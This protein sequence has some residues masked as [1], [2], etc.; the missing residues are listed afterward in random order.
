MG[1]GLRAKYLLP[2]CC[3]FKKNPI[4]FYLTCNMTMLWKS[5]IMTY[6]PHRQGPGLGLCAQNVGYHVAAFVILLNLICNMTMFWKLN[7]D[8]LT[9]DLVTFPLV[10]WV[11][12][13]IWLYRFLIFASLLTIDPIPRVARG[14]G[15]RLW[16]KYL[17][18]FR[19]IR[20]SL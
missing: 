20:G 19:C 16:A 14:G 13:G 9:Y 6:L 10:S 18:P 5:W 2:C 4:T 3:C 8:L 12:C 15:G 11:K 17:L 1:R 7:Y